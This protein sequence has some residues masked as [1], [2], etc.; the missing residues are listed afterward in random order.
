MISNHVLQLIDYVIELLLE[1]WGHIIPLQ[2]E[3][4]NIRKANKRTYSAFM[5]F[6][7]IYLSSDV[8]SIRTVHVYK[9]ERIPP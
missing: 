2:I 7:F 4:L 9:V 8:R 3:E 6:L 5:E 1:A